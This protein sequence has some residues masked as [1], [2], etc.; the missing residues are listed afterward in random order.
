MIQQGDSSVTQLFAEYK[1]VM[2]AFD[3]LPDSNINAIIAYMHAQQQPVA[4]YEKPDSGEIK[5]PLPDTIAHADIVVGIKL[6]QQIP[7]S[8]Q[9]RPLTR[10]IKMEVVPGTPTFFVGDLRGKLYKLSP[11]GP[12]LFMDIAKLRRNFVQE[13]GIATGFGSFAFHPDFQNNGLLYTTHAEHA[14]AAKPDFSCANESIVTLQ[15]VLTE[16][17]TDPKGVA[18]DGTSREIMRVDMPTSIHG[19]QEITFNTSAKKGDADYG[20]LYI[21]VGDGGSTATGKPLVSATPDKIWGSIIRIDPL[22][23]NS[24]NHQYGIPVDNPYVNS[25]DGKHLPEIFAFGFRNPHRLSFSQRGQ[26]LAAN[27]G[28]HHIEAVDW[29][30]PGHFYGWPIREGTF[31]E[32]FFN[33][34]GHLY[35]LPAND[36]EYHVT[37]PVAQFDHDEGTAICGGFAYDGSAIDELKDKYVFG[38]IGSGTLFCVNMD[39]LQLG[40]QA[41]IKKWRVAMDGRLTSLCELSGSD[42]VDMR[43]ARDEKGEL[44]IFTKVDGKI[45]KLIKN[46]AAAKSK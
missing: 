1:M 5:D 16:W 18:F 23:S 17:K 14:G 35:P 9:E 22:G 25:K 30:L 44:Y 10:I 32:R 41:T 11:K 12:V 3:F 29:I 2:P 31:A 24:A 26:L 6:M 39:A 19:M 34:V 38:D 43:F 8:A 40:K 33:G 4:K 21:G 36:A 27:I 46:S 13:P 45:Y 7:P 42:R 28:E 37:Y 15:W 20:L